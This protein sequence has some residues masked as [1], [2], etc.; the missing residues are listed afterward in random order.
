MV[1]ESGVVNS[2]KKDFDKEADHWEED[3][4][5][6]KLAGDIAAAMTKE[7][8]LT[9]DMDVLDYGCGTGLLT[10]LLQPHI[11]T[12]TGIDSSQGMID[13]LN[14]KIRK[15]SLINVKTKFLDLE[16]GGPLEEMFH[17]I[18][19]SMTMHHVRNPAI[20]IGRFYK[21]LHEKGYLCIADLDPEEGKFHGNNRGVFH[22]GFHRSALE[23]DFIGAGFKNIRTTTAATVMKPVD[24]DG[25]GA[26]TIFLIT[27]QK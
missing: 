23:R 2:L 17:L 19:C 15:Y 6:A 22:F 5:R 21:C 8:P 16:E 12:V 1:K 9:P 7:V 3:P 10:L 13:V 20:L 4:D 14:A 24:H 27:G 18:T 26:F 25:M 11:R